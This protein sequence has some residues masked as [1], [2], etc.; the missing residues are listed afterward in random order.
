MSDK[1][2][3]PSG[4]TYDLIDFKKGDRCYT[5]GIEHDGERDETKVVVKEFEFIEYERAD[6]NHTDV[7]VEKGPPTMELRDPKYPDIPIKHQNAMEFFA[8]A[9]MAVLGLYES[10]AHLE[11]TIR[12][13]IKKEYPKCDVEYFY[14]EA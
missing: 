3:P 6:V 10:I 4:K 5:A 11:K 12:A 2:V 13:H 8:S 1:I 14:G 7:E 9:Q